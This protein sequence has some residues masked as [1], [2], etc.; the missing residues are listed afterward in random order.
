MRKSDTSAV[1]REWLQ[2]GADD[3]RRPIVAFDLDSASTVVGRDVESPHRE[4]WFHGGLVER[5]DVNTFL[6]RASGV[7]PRERVRSFLWIVE[8]LGHGPRGQKWNLFAVH[9]APEKPPAG[10]L[11]DHHPTISTASAPSASVSTLRSLLPTF[12]RV[13]ESNDGCSA[14]RP[15]DNTALLPIT[16]RRARLSGW[17][18]TASGISR[19]PHR[20]SATQ[21][22]DSRS[23]RSGCRS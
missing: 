16:P 20:W 8:N 14:G 11:C 10:S 4:H 6:N 17:P 12:Y 21:Q 9:P 19:R 18:L 13:L 1:S 22:R 2:Q 5:M 3:I 7:L 15:G 23:A